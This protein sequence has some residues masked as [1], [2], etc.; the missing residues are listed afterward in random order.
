MDNEL[1]QFLAYLRVTRNASE[2]TCKAYAEDIGQFIG[3]VESAGQVSAPAVT[4]AMVRG[5]IGSRPELARASR[6]R[7]AA[8]LR[9]FFAFLAQRGIVKSSP[10]AG[11]RTPRQDH[12]L[13][14]FLR[15]AEIEA[16]MS[17]PTALAKDRNLQLRDIALLEMLYAGGMRAGELIQLAPADVD[18]TS[19]T[20]IVTG[21]GN[22]QRIVLLG[23]KA[24][25]AAR[26][27]L[28]DS[29]PHLVPAGQNVRQM[30]VNYRGEPL[31]DRGVRKLFDKYCAHVGSA[32]KITPH[33]LRHSFATHLL[34]GGADLRIVQELLGHASVAT[35]QIYTH[36]T[37]ERLQEVYRR[38]HPLASGS[39]K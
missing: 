26:S 27:Y 32:L 15:P 24:C 36:V 7:K 25:A 8:A 38:A 17:A 34:A 22:K 28:A 39:R 19:K 20:A 30:F 9:S 14:K 23:E 2:N 12:R 6:A 4:A 18:L 10:A 31:S 33:V 11:L 3:Y 1:D 13:P 21:K 29:R 16:L 5:F 37:P 35:T